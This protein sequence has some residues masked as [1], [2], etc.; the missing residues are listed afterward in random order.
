[1]VQSKLI[2]RGLIIC[3]PHDFLHADGGTASS[4]RKFIHSYTD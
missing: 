1:L 2:E 4:S 3:A